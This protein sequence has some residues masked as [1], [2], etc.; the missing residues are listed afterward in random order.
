MYMVSRL[1]EYCLDTLPQVCF[2]FLSFSCFSPDHIH[3][4]WMP[5]VTLYCIPVCNTRHM[6]VNLFFQRRV[7]HDC[8]AEHLTNAFLQA[9]CIK[10]AAWLQHFIRCVFWR[11]KMVL[12]SGV[13]CNMSMH[14]HNQNL[15]HPQIRMNST[16]RRLKCLKQYNT[17][18]VK[19]SVTFCMS[20]VW[21]VL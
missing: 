6:S 14:F 20:I 16:V 3:S 19:V 18:E 13:H 2:R 7:W 5:L 1:H 4:E 17:F 11:C 15:P 9:V 21:P 8:G 10:L 12:E